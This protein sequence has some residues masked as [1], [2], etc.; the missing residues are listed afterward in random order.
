MDEAQVS[1]GPN[2]SSGDRLVP[3]PLQPGADAGQSAL[4]GAVGAAD[5][6][7]DLGRGVALQTAGE[8]LPFAVAAK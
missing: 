1:V 5:L 3:H 8:D 7:A 6:L 4:D 2:Q